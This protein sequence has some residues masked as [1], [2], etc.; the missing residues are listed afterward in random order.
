L[1]H[2]LLT[3]LLWALAA[4]AF[5]AAGRR[6]GA[7]G[8]N[9]L[10]IPVAVVLLAVLHA[11]RF[12]TLWPAELTPGRGGWLALSGVVGLA[13]GDLCYFHA[14][15]I[16]GARLGALLLSTWPVM[17]VAIDAAQGEPL[18]FA[19]GA[20][21]TLVLLGVTVVLLDRAPPPP[22][23]DAPRELRAVAVLAGLLG[24][25]GQAGGIALSKHGM[26]A[27]GGAPVDPL[28]ATLVRMVAALAAIWLLAGLSGRLR[29][30]AATARDPRA[31]SLLALGALLGPTLGVWCSL[32][33]L[34]RTS[35]A[36]AATLMGTV[37]VLLLPLHW[38]VY[39]EPV[40]VR[41]LAGTL[42]AFAGT[43]VLFANE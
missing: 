37:P 34:T 30:A 1:S 13:L 9:L 23:A 20:G 5:A 33:A 18:R 42:I 32:I 7:L 12:G 25:A 3:A 27:G 29:S 39:R 35:M 26:L 19:H 2:A 11:W 6:V 31:L 15:A 41:A 38:L 10:R 28:G 24:A 36:A 4:L 14:L 8:V 40:R 21:I 22:Q 16:L 17:S 43:V